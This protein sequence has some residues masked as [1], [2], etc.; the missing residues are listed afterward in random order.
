MERSVIKRRPMYPLLF[1]LIA[2]ALLLLA[3][4]ASAPAV[5]TPAPVAEPEEPAAD[6]TAALVDGNAVKAVNDMKA[7]DMATAASARTPVPTTT[8]GLLDREISAFSAEKGL[9]HIELNTDLNFHLLFYSFLGFYRILP[10]TYMS[11]VIQNSLLI[12]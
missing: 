10:H 11:P 1:G 2:A 4:C 3:A 12:F 8:P 9:N 7:S 6:S 5:S